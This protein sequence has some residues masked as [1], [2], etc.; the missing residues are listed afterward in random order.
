MRLTWAWKLLRT[1]ATISRTSCAQ[2]KT[3][4]SVSALFFFYCFFYCSDVLPVQESDQP[5]W[6]T[7]SSTRKEKKK[8]NDGKIINVN[9]FSL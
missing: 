5:Q 6:G 2:I 1:G 9:G 7:N 3:E 4:N 8:K